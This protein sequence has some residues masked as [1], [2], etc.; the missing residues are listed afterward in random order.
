MI[1]VLLVIYKNLNAVITLEHLDLIRIPLKLKQTPMLF[2]Y[3][4]LMIWKIKVKMQC[5]IYHVYEITVAFKLTFRLKSCDLSHARDI[6]ILLLKP[7]RIFASPLTIDFRSFSFA[8]S[9]HIPIRIFLYV[10]YTTFK[11]QKLT[12]CISNFQTIRL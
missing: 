11:R 7:S 4:T 10:K 5:C 12:I 1:L 2:I 3:V 8:F 9:T 6:C